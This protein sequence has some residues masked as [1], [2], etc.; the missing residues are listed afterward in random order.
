MLKNK[1]SSMTPMRVQLLDSLGFSWEVRQSM[2][3]PRHTWQQRATQL[4]DFCKMHGHFLVPPDK[5]PE[6]WAWCVEQKLRLLNLHRHG[7]DATQTMKTK[8]NQDRVIILESMGFTKDVELAQS[9]NGTSPGL[10]EEEEDDDEEDNVDEEDDHEP[11]RHYDGRTNLMAMD[12][13]GMVGAVTNP[14]LHDSLKQP[15]G[16][17]REHDYSISDSIQI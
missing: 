13:M 8:M 1:K 17:Y 14:Q 6:L 7:T 12:D 5:M 16:H 11:I 3:G 4:R 2:A 9:L 10:P 15:P